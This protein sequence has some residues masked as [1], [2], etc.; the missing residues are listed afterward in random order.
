MG[1]S[2]IRM[3][4]ESKA[5]EKRGETIG[6]RGERRSRCLRRGPRSA[7]IWRRTCRG[8]GQRAGA[9]AFNGRA[10]GS[11]PAA[12]AGAGAL[13]LGPPTLSASCGS[14]IRSATASPWRP[15]WKRTA[16]SPGSP[17]LSGCWASSRSHS[18]LS[19]VSLPLSRLIT[20]CIPGLAASASSPPQPQPQPQPPT[21]LSWK[22][23]LM[24]PPLLPF[25]FFSRPLHALISISLPLSTSSW[26]Q[27]LIS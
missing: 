5:E 21:L 15:T 19:S 3:R 24:P 7:R 6:R 2:L 26:I 10:S 8:A 20:D 16:S 12:A 18:L 17:L 1:V 23:T 13:T 4:I 22:G 25:I 14:R 27:H 9:R 11:N